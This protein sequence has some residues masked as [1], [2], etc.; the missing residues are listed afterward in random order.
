MSRNLVPLALFALAGGLAIYAVWAFTEVQRAVQEAVATGQLAMAGSE[1]DVASFYMTSSGQ[2][3]VL[4]V[5][6]AALGWILRR[7]APSASPPA[8][9]RSPRSEETDDDD[10]DDLLDAAFDQNSDRG[11]RTA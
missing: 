7:T 5:V 9:A 11:A 6:L 3:A 8:A 1:F 4:A 2:Y 10:L